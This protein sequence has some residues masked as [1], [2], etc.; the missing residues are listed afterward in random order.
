MYCV[1][2]KRGE[3]GALQALGYG[4]NADIKIENAYTTPEN[5][6]M[7]GRVQVSFELVNQAN[8]TVAIMVDLAIHFIKAIGKANPSVFE[9]KLLN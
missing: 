6:K 5:A 8:K 9:L 1:A 3:K 4:D 7:G 2:R